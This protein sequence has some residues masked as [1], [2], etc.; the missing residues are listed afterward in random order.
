M[1]N[2][3]FLEN[4]LSLHKAIKLILANENLYKIFIVTNSKNFDLEVSKNIF[5]L[6][7][8]NSKFY[9]ALDKKKIEN[10]R[11]LIIYESKQDIENIPKNNK[12]FFLQ[13]PFASVEWKNLIDSILDIHEMKEKEAIHIDIK[14]TEIENYMK[15]L[16]DKWVKEQAP[17]YAKDV[18]RE[19]ILKLI[20]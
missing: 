3:L 1:K 20:S 17:K 4:S 16:I 6:L 7:I 8:V 5:D 9:N 10:Q 14:S 13:K 11:L 12:Y 18:I 15:D 19:E 2:I